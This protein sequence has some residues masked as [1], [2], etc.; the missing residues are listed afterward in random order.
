MG[1]PRIYAGGDEP[2]M[3]PL[4][5]QLLNWN[6]SDM[7]GGSKAARKAAIRGKVCEENL[8]RIEA[9]DRRLTLEELNEEFRRLTTNGE[10][11]PN[12]YLALPVPS[13]SR[14]GETENQ[15]PLEWDLEMAQQGP[16]VSYLTTCPPTDM[17]RNKQNMRAW[18]K[19]KL[20]TPS[21]KIPP[22]FPDNC[23]KCELNFNTIF[24]N[25]YNCL[26]CP[27]CGFNV[28]KI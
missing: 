7:K 18:E 13:T 26:Y 17:R 19:T 28:Y 3:S 6:L 11:V 12:R 15:E 1:N 8:A 14:K 23:A 9:K 25:K 5:R 24:K 20:K 10:L 2:Q 4:D 22:L 27:K 16:V 21:P